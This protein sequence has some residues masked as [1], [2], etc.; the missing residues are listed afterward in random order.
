[1]KI[2]PPPE[3]S[4]PLF[5]SNPPLKVEVLLSPHL[6]ENFVGVLNPPAER[7]GGGGGGAHYVHVRDRK[8]P[9]AILHQITCHMYFT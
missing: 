6:F 5:S 4:Y 2:A 7:G 3:K 8:I 1:M 9:Y